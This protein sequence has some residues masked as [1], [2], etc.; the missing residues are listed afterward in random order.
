M[1]SIKM[2]MMNAPCGFSLRIFPKVQPTQSNRDDEWNGNRHIHPPA[3]SV[4]SEPTT[5]AE[6]TR[7]KRHRQKDGCNDC[8]SCNSTRFINR[9][10]P[11]FNR[12]FCKHCADLFLCIHLHSLEFVMYILK[13]LGY[14]IC[15]FRIIE[16]RP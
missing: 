13:V 7:D 15:G 3:I 2:I 11:C 5:H 1:F 14:Q 8:K 16:L 6:N 12:N 4:E 9:L 10:F